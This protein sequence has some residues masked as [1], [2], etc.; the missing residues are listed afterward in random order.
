MEKEKRFTVRKMTIIGVLG[1][2]SAVL[3]MTPLGFIPVGPT[4]ATI[5]HIPVII[6]AL[7][8][9]P[10][11]GGFVGL[12]FG[13]FSI[14]Q[15]ITNPTPVS[16][17]F[18]NP[19][20]SIL[21]RV[22]IGI[23]SSYVYNR[24]KKMGKEKTKILLYL[25]LIG[26]ISYLSYG[27]YINIKNQS[28]IWLSLMNIGLIALTL[29]IIYF[30]ATK[31]KDRALDIIISTTIGTLTNT[32]GV[33]TMIYIFYAERFVG[34]IGGDINTARKVIMGIGVAN[35]LP[36]T[37]IGIIIVTSVVGALKSRR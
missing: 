34:A 25:I 26:I 30:T 21:P 23:V 37:I 3:G 28:S 29:I 36:E 15:A 27:I 8:E 5:M 12:I 4:R 33:L 13:I 22:L 17:V 2:I 14:F 7:M 19:I 10:V 9:G 6:G 35:G 18:L 1:A 16:F 11:V 31:L 20:V 32:V 24:L